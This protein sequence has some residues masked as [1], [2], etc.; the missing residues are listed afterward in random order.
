MRDQARRLMGASTRWIARAAFLL[1]AGGAAADCGPP[2]APDA[3]LIEAPATAAAIAT[4]HATM[5]N[6]DGRLWRIE[7]TPPSYL[8]GTFHVAVGGIE[9]PGP[10]LSALV[11][12]ADGLYLEIDSA[13]MEADFAAWSSDPANVFRQTSE[14]LTDTMTPEERRH[15]EEVLA[16]YGMPLEVAETLRPLMLFGL[17]SVPPCAL[18]FAEV[19]GLDRALEDRAL[20]EGIAVR[21]LESVAEQIAALDDDPGAMDTVLRMMLS[22]DPTD[23]TLWFTNLALY[24]TRH[25]GAMWTYGVD[26]MTELVGAEEARRLAD[27]FWDRM[28]ARRNRTMVERALPGLREGGKVVA[29]GALHLPGEDGLVAL[30]RREGFTLTPVAEPAPAAGTTAAPSL[31]N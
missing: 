30:L 26:R 14:G 24:R 5:P 9:D 28:V 22:M 4:A 27:L 20:A 2:P 1:A 7:T 25:I 17:L 10:V 19:P 21:G 6:A 3:A 15:A 12:A 23:R 13:S 18:A 16:Q 11:D 29:V 8:V 31:P